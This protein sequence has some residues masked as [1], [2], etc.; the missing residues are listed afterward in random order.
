MPLS[1]MPLSRILVTRMMLYSWHPWARYG[2]WDPAPQTADPCHQFAAQPPVA[3]LKTSYLSFENLDAAFGL[4]E[5]GLRSTG[6]IHC[7]EQI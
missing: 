5:D 7:A 4:S 6:S 1:R 2:P 3:A